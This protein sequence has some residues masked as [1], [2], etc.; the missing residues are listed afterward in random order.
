MVL[1][2]VT[3]YFVTEYKMLTH[4]D[5][6]VFRTKFSDEIND[7][8]LYVH[9]EGTISVKSDFAEWPVPPKHMYR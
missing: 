9:Q 7:V 2:Y 4:R 5:T 6:I 1:N 3:L 8:R